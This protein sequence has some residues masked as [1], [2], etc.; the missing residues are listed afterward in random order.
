[1]D[2]FLPALIGL[3]L[4]AAASARAKDEFLISHWCGPTEFSR[5]RFAELARANFNVAMIS[6]SVEQ[7][8][9]AL[10][11]CRDEGIKG[12]VIDHRIMARSRR[13]KDFESNLD[14]VVADY[15]SHPALWGYFLTDEPNSARFK[16]IAQV[17]EYLLGKDPGH[18]PFVNLF[19]TYATSQ[20]LGNPT[21]EHHV[22]EYLRVVRP[23]LLSYDH[24]AL[25]DKSER[26][27]Y[28][29]NLEIIRRQGIKHKTPFSYI[30]LSVPHGP[31]RDPSETDLRWQVNTALAYGARG[32]MY[33]TYTTPI[34]P[35]WNF[36][37]AIIDEHGKP[38][39]KYE[40]VTRINAEL[41]KLAPTLMRLQSVA[42]Y[43]T[44]PAPV[45]ARALPGDG[46]VSRVDGG[47]FVIGQFNSDTGEKYAMFV[48][49]SLRQPA[50][51][52]ITFA[53][54]V[55]LFEIS[56]LTGR[57][58][59]LRVSEEAGRGVWQ[60]EFAPGEGRLVR[61]Q[62]TGDLALARWENLPTFRPRVMLNPSCQFHNVIK[63]EEGVQL[64]NEARNMYDIALR[65][66]DELRRDGRVDVFVS[67]AEREQDV[68]LR[69]ETELTR[70]LNCDAL[71]SLHSDATGKK[72]DPGGGTWTFYATQEGKRL[73]EHVQMPLL[74]AIRSFYP[75]VQFR[76]IRTHWYRL[77][78]LHEA[79]CPASLT[80][81]LFHTNPA[82][83]EMLKDP[84]CQEEMARAI[85][86]GVLDYFGLARGRPEVYR[87]GENPVFLLAPGC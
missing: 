33:F 87:N 36:R 2:R 16:H 28:F 13:D 61:I 52:R 27:D 83:R 59:A 56:R 22:D 72:D 17:N 34:D 60:A 5:E 9:Q 20:Q 76:G 63:G 53:H 86:R 19:P 21:Y 49:R 38:T 15:G 64:Y 44:A 47:E 71:V 69:Y 74:E 41:R 7:N 82:E 29:A 3:V 25:L 18:V 85:A 81:V 73:A 79:G 65:V 43:H 39:A 42:V 78:V 12:L 31:Y 77:W 55:V 6:G 68:S 30:L 66:R 70:H 10:D 8:R 58:R 1:M 50:S 23:K 46:L 32:I 37:N 80:E 57:E 4:L 45:E 54:K 24:Y 11:W 48:N 40:Q 35:N 75:K 26:G 51:A 84:A 14:A 62:T 67:R